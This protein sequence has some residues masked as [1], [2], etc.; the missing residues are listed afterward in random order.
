VPV[1]TRTPAIEQAVRPS[2]AYR[3]V[4]V[5]GL[6]TA[7]MLGA[8]LVADAALMPS[9]AV[10]RPAA[11]PAPGVMV[12]DGDGGPSRRGIESDWALLAVLG[13]VLVAGAGAFSVYLVRRPA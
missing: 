13:G 1:M 11:V 12:R 7:G 8:P 9:A 2:G 3:G 10:V 6:I 4:V 5:A